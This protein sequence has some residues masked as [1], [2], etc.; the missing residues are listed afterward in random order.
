MNLFTLIINIHVACKVFQLF[1]LLLAEA[2]YI[3][4]PN[5]GSKKKNDK[6]FSPFVALPSKRC[7]LSLRIIEQIYR[8][9]ATHYGVCRA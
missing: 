6:R 1:A 3:I 9:H 5:Y 2:F 8:G 7:R 4:L